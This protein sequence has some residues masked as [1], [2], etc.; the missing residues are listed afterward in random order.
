MRYFC[1]A[2]GV[3]T[4]A[5][6]TPLYGLRCPPH[7]AKHLEVFKALLWDFH[8]RFLQSM[9]NHSRTPCWGRGTIH[10][11]KRFRSGKSVFPVANAGLL[12]DHR[13]RVL[14]GSITRSQFNKGR[15]PGRL[16]VF[17]CAGRPNHSC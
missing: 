4:R 9:R 13:D 5:K 2:S 11:A 15:L 1:Q 12:W 3:N 17:L 6:K 7:S 16:F 14:L 10:K 8:N